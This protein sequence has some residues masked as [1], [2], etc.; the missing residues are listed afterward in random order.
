MLGKK[1]EFI[2]WEERGQY[3]QGVDYVLEVALVV[4]AEDGEVQFGEV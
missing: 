2:H 4:V 3:V 1:C